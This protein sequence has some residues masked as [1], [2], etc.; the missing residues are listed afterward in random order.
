MAGPSNIFLDLWEALLTE[1]SSAIGQIRCL[2]AN[3]RD[4]VVLRARDLTE[5]LYAWRVIADGIELPALDSDGDA[6]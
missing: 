6:D 1:F 2:D 3:E 4:A 5:G